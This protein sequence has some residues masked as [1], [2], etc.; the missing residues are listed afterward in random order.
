MRKHNKQRRPEE[1]IIHIQGATA[2]SFIP[3]SQLQTMGFPEDVRYD[4]AQ[5]LCAVRA[6]DAS[7]LRNNVQSIVFPH[8]EV[9]STALLNEG[10]KNSGINRIVHDNALLTSFLAYGDIVDAKKAPEGKSFPSFPRGLLH[11][12]VVCEI[13]RLFQEFGRALFTLEY[14][15]SIDSS[16]KRY[17]PQMKEIVRF[18][19]EIVPFG[20]V[21]GRPHDI[22]AMPRVR[23]S[24]LLVN[25]PW[26]GKGKKPALVQ[27][28]HYLGETTT[29]LFVPSEKEQH[30]YI[31]ADCSMKSPSTL[32]ERN[33]GKI[34]FGDVLPCEQMMPESMVTVLRHEY[35]KLIRG[36]QHEVSYGAKTSDASK[37]NIE[38]NSCPEI[39]L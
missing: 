10:L 31:Q 35:E 30:L 17:L 24:M 27:S 6:F 13:P 11:P 9:D 18:L 14:D 19:K 26:Q 4:V 37:I 15:A 7:T 2:L 8:L 25:A 36:N 32:H 28:I 38:G 22:C 21:L 39:G 16:V 5:G 20:N 12:P 1:K 34:A 33:R 3:E 23:I 29:T